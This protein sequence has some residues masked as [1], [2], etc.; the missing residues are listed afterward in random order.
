MGLNQNTWKLN[1]WY[2]QSVAEN[3]SYSAKDP[4]TLFALGGNA[5]GQLGLNNTTN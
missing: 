5:N 1:Q 2:E 3:V 4:H